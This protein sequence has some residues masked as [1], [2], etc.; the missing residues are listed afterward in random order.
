MRKPALPPSIQAELDRYVMRD[1][2]T[3][4]LAL[5]IQRIPK[6]LCSTP[7]QVEQ[8]LREVTE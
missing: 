6:L 4:A 3:P 5:A 2:I 8:R 1:G 7:E